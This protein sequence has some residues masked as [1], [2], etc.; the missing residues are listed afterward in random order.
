MRTCDDIGPAAA[1]AVFLV[2]DD[3]GPRLIGCCCRC[4]Y[5]NWCHFV[6][7][8]LHLFDEKRDSS[9]TTGQQTTDLAATS[10]QNRRDVRTLTDASQQ[11]TDLAATSRQ[12]RRDVRT[13]T[14]DGVTRCPSVRTTGQGPSSTTDPETLRY[15]SGLST[16]RSGL[17]TY[18]SGLSSY[19]SGLQTAIAL[20]LLIDTAW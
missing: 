16:Y 17:L 8:V 14:D 4:C 5:N 6:A 11:T 10:R 7:D 1:V 20:T 3:T 12:N 19:R 18:R 15:Q 2:C 13:L 9:P